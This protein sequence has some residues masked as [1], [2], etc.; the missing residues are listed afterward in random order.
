MYMPE[1]KSFFCLRACLLGRIK[2]NAIHRSEKGFLM[3]SEMILRRFLQ[4]D[5]L[6]E[7]QNFLI[8]VFDEKLTVIWEF[9]PRE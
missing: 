1:I 5:V 2:K 3:Q 4:L 6:V 7:S 9:G 8:F